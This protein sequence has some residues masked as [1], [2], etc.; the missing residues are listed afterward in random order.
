MV[1]EK[2]SSSKAKTD[3]TPEDSISKTHHTV[4]VNGQTHKYTATTGTKILREE[5]ESKDK[6][7]EGV[8]A[9]ASVFFVAYTLDPP[10]NQATEY[11]RSKRSLTFSFNGVKRVSFPATHFASK[12]I[13]ICI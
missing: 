7:S 8:K 10:D 6:E 5:S 9:R 2:E 11:Y 12:N 1:T 13:A 4:V 3:A